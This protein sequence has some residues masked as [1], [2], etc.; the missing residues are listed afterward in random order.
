MS[1]HD[2]IVDEA[3]EEMPYLRR[4]P[5]STPWPLVTAF[6]VTFIFAG[7]VTNPAVSVVG[8][9]AGL[10][11]LVGWFREV[12]PEEVTEEIPLENAAEPAPGPDLGPVPPKPLRRVVP[13]EIHPYRS[14]LFGGLV[15]GV[16][17]AVVAVGWGL[18]TG[19][20]FWLPVNLLAGILIPAVGDAD[21]ATLGQFHAAWFVAALCLHVALSVLV[22]TVFVVALPMMPR[23][24][25]LA[26]GVIAPILW[27]G[28][29]WA[30]LRV[31]DPALE[32]YISWPWFLGSQVAF[33]L[34]CAA[35]IS[36]FNLIP[37]QVGRSV[38]ERLELEQGPGGG[39]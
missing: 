14:G 20:G 21:V 19:E 32:Q 35:I 33:G 36:R 7:I 3:R 28:V 16:A 31:V 26:G 2:P 22:G 24:P 34:A 4:I 25:L 10:V 13:E 9:I 17:M 15:G 29:A 5:R 18:T 37:L 38:E 27:T 23:R 39:S 11:G 12:F 1:R 6:G 8:A 30:S